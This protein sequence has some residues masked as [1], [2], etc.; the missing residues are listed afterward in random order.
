MKI[1]IVGL[2]VAGVSLAVAFGRKYET[3]GFDESINR[4][5]QLQKGNDVTGDIPE[6]TFSAATKLKF[7]ADADALKDCNV[8][9]ITVST[10]LDSFKKPNLSLLFKATELVAHYMH[11]G[12]LVIYESTVYPG[13]TEDE[14]VPILEKNSNLKFNDDFF[15]GYSPVRISHGDN[16]HTLENVIKITAGSTP[17]AAVQVDELYKS[18][19]PA[20]TH[21]VS[22][23]K[24][25]ESAKVIENT[26]RDLNIAFVNEL[27]ILFHR[28]GVDTL[29]VLEAAETKW[30]FLR[31]RPGLVGGNSIGVDPYYLT[32]KAAAVDYQPEVILSGRRIND[33]MGLYVA[34]EVIKMMIGKDMRIK[35]SRVL[36]LGITFKENCSDIR[37]SP[38][39]K[40]ARALHEFGCNVDIFDPWADP[41]AVKARYDLTSFKDEEQLVLYGYDT[42]VLAVAHDVF[43]ALPVE[44]IISEHT[45]LYDVKGI[46]NKDIVD[47]RL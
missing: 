39:V 17:E 29:E 28:I 26:Q 41:A 36:Q 47:G 30:N 3:V 31:F 2:G 21:P 15:C 32:Y 43:K 9:I 34:S 44:N 27:A 6:S 25:A 33:H 13:C 38:A 1:G 19:I 8:F 11:P 24:T 4:V 46:Y 35:G 20:G 12:A 22:S 18:I 10:P 40:L 14:C 37:N 16:V 45:V 5:A 7:S 23:I 42:V